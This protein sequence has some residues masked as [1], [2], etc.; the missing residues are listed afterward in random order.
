MGFSVILGTLQ[1]R[2]YCVFKDS[3]YAMSRSMLSF[4]IFLFVLFVC[5]GT[6]AFVFDLIVDLSGDQNA[7]EMSWK[8]FWC[9]GFTF[10]VSGTLAVYLFCQNL[11][12][13]VKQHLIFS[14]KSEVEALMHSQRHLIHLTARYLLL[15]IIASV[16]SLAMLPITLW[17]AKDAHHL[18][19]GTIIAVDVAINVLMLYL[20]YTFAD[21]HYRTCCGK[22]DM[23]FVRLL[24]MNMRRV[25][26]KSHDAVRSQ[27]GN[28]IVEMAAQSVGSTDDGIEKVEGQ[29]S[30][31]VEISVNGGGSEKMPSPTRMQ[32]DPSETA[33]RNSEILKMISVI[34]NL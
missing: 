34:N 25:V 32:S 7:Y 19:Y 24:S 31:T 27:D 33:L 28:A 6:A 20:Q 14:D 1:I 12:N 26:I 13:L 11:W 18:H 5:F 10:F 30:V 23:C 16:S 4:F 17:S 3:V 29:K 21:S 9:E 15:F 8:M 2:L 22:L